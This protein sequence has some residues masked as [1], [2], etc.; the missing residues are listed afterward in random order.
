M[1]GPPGCTGSCMAWLCCLAEPAWG[2]GSS[3]SG[4]STYSLVNEGGV[5]CYCWAGGNCFQ[6]SREGCGVGDTGQ[7]GWLQ[8]RCDSAEQAPP[9]DRVWGEEETPVLA[10]AAAVVVLQVVSD[11]AAHSKPSWVGSVHTVVALTGQPK[12]LS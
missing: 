1:E 10:L 2:G 11:A 6:L 12:S 8:R 9:G 3:L 4:L 5:S 7:G